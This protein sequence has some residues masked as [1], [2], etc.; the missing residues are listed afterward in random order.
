MGVVLTIL[1]LVAFVLEARSLD[2]DRRAAIEKD[3]EP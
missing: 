1:D 3:A 2:R